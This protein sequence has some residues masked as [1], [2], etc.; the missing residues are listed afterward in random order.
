MKSDITR[1]DHIIVDPIIVKNMGSGFTFCLA[2]NVRKQK[3]T[4]PI[5]NYSFRNAL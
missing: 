5:L 4:V 1:P 3:K 2:L